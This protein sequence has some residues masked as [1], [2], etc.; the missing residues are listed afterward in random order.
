VRTF[1]EPDPAA[2]ARLAAEQLAGAIAD[3]LAQRGAAHVALSGGGTPKPAYELLGALVPDWSAVQIWFADERCVGPDDPESNARLVRESLD[4]PGATVHRMRGELGPHDGAAAYERDLADV[5]L[6]VVLLGMGPD[7]HTASLFPD[8]PALEA[9]GLR[10][11]GV[12]GA[13]KPPPERISLTRETL[14]GARRLI[15]LVTGADKAP[16]LAAALGAPSRA[17]PMSLLE[18]GRLDVIADAAALP[19]A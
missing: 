16:A 3:A 14:D 10:A 4:A 12:H 17:T 11:V 9:G 13:P 8:N 18:R 19:G 2:A 7:G 1:R 6:D 15:L 5:V